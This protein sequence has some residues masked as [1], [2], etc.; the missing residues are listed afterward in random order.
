MELNDFIANFAE[1]F[2]DTDPE[3]FTAET[4]YHELDEWSSL[5]G[6]LVIGMVLDKYGKNLKADVVR[7]C[8]TIKDL[9]NAINE[10]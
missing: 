5:T 2:D 4:K 10:L 7:Q 9:F 3:E 8:V 6:L 1:Q